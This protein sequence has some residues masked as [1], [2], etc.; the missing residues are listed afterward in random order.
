M[1]CSKSKS[2]VHQNVVR[3]ANGIMVLPNYRHYPLTGR[4]CTVFIT[5]FN[6]ILTG[7]KTYRVQRSM[8]AKIYYTNMKKGIEFLLYC[9]A[10]KYFPSMSDESYFKVIIAP[11]LYTGIFKINE[12]F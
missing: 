2:G 5:S 11:H 9:A 6:M 8:K 10:V 3:L 1:S 12:H 7:K 4:F